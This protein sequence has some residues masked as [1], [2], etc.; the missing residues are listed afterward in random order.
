MRH[1]RCLHY[2]DDT[3]KIGRIG[4]VIYLNLD[5]KESCQL[6]VQTKVTVFGYFLMFP[7]IY[8]TFK[9]NNTAG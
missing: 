7:R 2:R 6:A 4:G 3:F 9:T 1:A 8:L 5:L